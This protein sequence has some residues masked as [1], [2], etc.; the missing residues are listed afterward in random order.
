MKE[1]NACQ[2][3]LLNNLKSGDRPTIQAHFHRDEFLG[4]LDDLVHE[5][6]ILHRQPNGCS[7]MVP[8]G[9]GIVLIRST[10]KAPTA[11]GRT[12]DPAVS[13]RD[14]KTNGRPE[15]PEA[16]LT[17]VPILNPEEQLSIW[18]VGPLRPHSTLESL[19]DFTLHGFPTDD[20]VSWTRRTSRCIGSATA[21]SAVSKPSQITL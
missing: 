19:G 4:G 15:F 20:V 5:G 9:V 2:G 3:R 12:M 7:G 6:L 14:R 18:I 10:H 1:L 16:R 13:H 11:A 8:T 21:N 17:G